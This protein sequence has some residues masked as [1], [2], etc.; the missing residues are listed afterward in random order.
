MAVNKDFDLEFDETDPTLASCCIRDIQDRKQAAKFKAELRSK[1]PVERAVQTRKHGA[2]IGLAKPCL[3]PEF[4]P[5]FVAA[6]FPIGRFVETNECNLLGVASSGTFA[7]CLALPEIPS[8]LEVSIRDWL[9][10]FESVLLCHRF[11][12]ATCRTCFLNENIRLPALVVYDC[13]ESVLTLDRMRLES[14]SE[15]SL[16]TRLTLVKRQ[17]AQEKKREMGSDDESEK[18]RTGRNNFFV[19]E[20]EGCNRSFHHVHV[21]STYKNSSFQDSGDERGNDSSDDL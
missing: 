6:K 5:S 15:T 11:K 9:D 2:E 12:Q 21:K 1:D 17:R 18:P 16:L 14:E 19:C 10:G 4:S 8:S 13:G 7:I 20:K 3:I